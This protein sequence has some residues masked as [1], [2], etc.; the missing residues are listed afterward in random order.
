M[1]HKVI[2]LYFLHSWRLLGLLRLDFCRLFLEFSP[3]VNHSLDDGHPAEKSD[4]GQRN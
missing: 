4:D 3:G 1:A 2:P